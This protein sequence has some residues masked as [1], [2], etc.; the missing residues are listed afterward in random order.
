MY[1]RYSVLSGVINAP[2]AVKQMAPNTIWGKGVKFDTYFSNS[3]RVAAKDSQHAGHG[4]LPKRY[5]Y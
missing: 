4:R 3:N 2:V 1:A 5:Y